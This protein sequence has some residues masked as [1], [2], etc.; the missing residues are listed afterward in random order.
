VHTVLQHVTNL[1]DENVRELATFNASPAP[2]Q[3]RE[4]GFLPEAF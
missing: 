3:M 4:A 2:S 1:E